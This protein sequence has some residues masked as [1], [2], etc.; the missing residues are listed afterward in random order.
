M[1]SLNSFMSP[2]TR[3]FRLRIQGFDP[4]IFGTN[5]ATSSLGSGPGTYSADSQGR[6]RVNNVQKMAAQNNEVGVSNALVS[7]TTTQPAT[8]NTPQNNMS[9]APT[10]TSGP[11]KPA[12]QAPAT[13]APIAPAPAATPAP[14]AASKYEAQAGTSTISVPPAPQPEPL[15]IPETAVN[16]AYQTQLAGALGSEWFSKTFGPYNG[17]KVYAAIQAGK[18]SPEAMKHLLALATEQRGMGYVPDARIGYRYGPIGV[19]PG[20]GGP[21]QAQ[22]GRLDYAT[23]MQLRT[24]E[25]SRNMALDAIRRQEQEEKA[26]ALLARKYKDVLDQ[27]PNR[28]QKL[29]ELY[30]EHKMIPSIQAMSRS[31]MNIVAKTPE[32]LNDPNTYGSP[33]YIRQFV[34][35]QLLEN[36]AFKDLS[37]QDIEAKADELL[38]KAQ[39]A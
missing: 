38:R 3:G 5:L 33:A 35:N 7:T 24:Y 22:S 16:A 9:T 37:Y 36:E 17:P 11:Q 18:L 31:H 2:I 28:E 14:V 13:S 30:T 20:G 26:K 34:I 39:V 32:K 19:N 4:K 12:L 15:P 6:V 23:S 21:G 8:K 29:E 1:T 10:T 27:A 25:R